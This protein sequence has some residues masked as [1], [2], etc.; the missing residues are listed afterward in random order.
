MTML[1]HYYTSCMHGL[2]EG[3]GF[4]TKAESPGISPQLD[5]TIAS[6]IGYRIP[7]SL[8]ER[9]TTQHPVALR[10]DYLGP[11][12]CILSCIQSSGPDEKGRDG[13]YFAH[14]VITNPQDFAVLSPIMFWRHSF[15]QTSDLSDRLEI[16]PVP[17]FELEPSLE[18]DSI[19]PFLDESNRRQWFRKLLTAV[20]QYSESK[21]PIIILDSNDNVASWIAAITFALP[22]ILRVSL[23]FSTYH[24]D[25]YNVP[26]CITGTTRPGDSVFRFSSNE[27]ISYFVLNA[28]DERISEVKESV[29][30]EF[31]CERY[32]PD[33]Y[34]DTLLD[35]FMTCNR[36]LPYRSSPASLHLDYIARF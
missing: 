6:M 4:Q 30:A 27:Y 16:S 15:W 20:V 10:Y 26:Y 21:R 14:T 11:N 18:L 2:S 28:L 25:P 8:D 35:F 29:Y 9:I 23:T 3:A 24:H 1:Q 13:N 36:L 32:S 33:L 22:P 17:S 19:W 7:P 34:E 31:V 5:K 12:R